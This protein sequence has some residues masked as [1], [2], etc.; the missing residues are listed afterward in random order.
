MEFR[1]D[2]EPRMLCKSTQVRAGLKRFPERTFAC[3]ANTTS[4]SRWKCPGT[5]GIGVGPRDGGSVFSEASTS[6]QE[7]ANP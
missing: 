4:S 5:L 3:S 7:R 1:K 6:Y 2:H